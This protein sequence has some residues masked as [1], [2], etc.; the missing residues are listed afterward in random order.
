M[1]F[2]TYLPIDNVDITDVISK[3]K[4]V[5]KTTAWVGNGSPSALFTN[6]GGGGG[7][8][9]NNVT[10][11]SRQHNQHSR[12]NYDTRPKV[13]NDVV[14]RVAEVYQRTL[15][16]IADRDKGNLPTMAAAHNEAAHAHG[17]ISS[18]MRPM[19]A[20]R[21]FKSKIFHRQWSQ[22]LQ[23]LPWKIDTTADTRSNRSSK[24]N[25]ATTDATAMAAS[26]QDLEHK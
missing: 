1:V 11:N 23:R 15:R 18:A 25:V 20:R 8:T 16:K 2:T 3:L 7:T 17:S 12:G 6:T 21:Y 26:V 22:D 4:S 24:A 5:Q 13:G 14:A 9:N 10:D 19:D